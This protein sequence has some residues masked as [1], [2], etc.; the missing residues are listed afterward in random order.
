MFTNWFLIGLSL[1]V[2]LFCYF[3]HTVVTKLVVI[4]LS[5]IWGLRGFIHQVK[6]REANNLRVSVHSLFCEGDLVS[7]TVS[8]V[9]TVE[10]FSHIT[11]I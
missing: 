6:L 2:N 10:S 3:M 5:L 1:N 9:F 8:P 4:F 11:M 7:G